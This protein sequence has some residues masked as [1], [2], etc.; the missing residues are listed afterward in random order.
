[1]GTASLCL[2][3][4]CANFF[5]T[6]P[7]NST[8]CVH[9]AVGRANA[10]TKYWSFESNGFNAMLLSFCSPLLGGGLKFGIHT[11]LETVKHLHFEVVFS[12]TYII[13]YDLTCR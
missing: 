12:E 1:M 13:S 6:T 10:V 4:Y 5:Y 2:E 11:I 7:C 9:L 3:H 8:R